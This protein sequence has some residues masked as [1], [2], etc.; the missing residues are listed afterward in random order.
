MEKL[1]EV[2]CDEEETSKGFRY[3]GDRLNA[4]G[5]C[6]TAVTSRERIGWMKFRECGEGYMGEGCL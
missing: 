3:S 5:D 1:V 4:S 6:E 2:L